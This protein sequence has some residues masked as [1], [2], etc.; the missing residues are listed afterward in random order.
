[1]GYSRIGSPEELSAAYGRLI[2]TVRGLQLLAGFCYAQFTDT[3][4]PANGLVYADRTPKFPLE[5]LARATRG[6]LDERER[7]AEREW[8]ALGP[9][10]DGSV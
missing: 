10:E 5:E 6:V 2:E 3:I 4:Q 7:R 8:Y 9:L 1:M